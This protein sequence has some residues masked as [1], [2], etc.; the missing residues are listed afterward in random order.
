MRRYAAV[1]EGQRELCTLDGGT[2]E[3][4]NLP[5]APWPYPWFRICI[6]KQAIDFAEGGAGIAEIWAE[7]ARFRAAFGPN[8]AIADKRARQAQAWMWNEIG[9]TLMARFK[10]HPEVAGQL[11]ALGDQVRAGLLTPAAAAR[12]LMAAFL[13]AEDGA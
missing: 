6:A 2:P 13:G 12:A 5:I 9:E 4:R 7:V 8:G 1:P 3:S 11:T 10:A